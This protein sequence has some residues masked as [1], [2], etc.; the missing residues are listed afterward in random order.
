[1]Y[2]MADDRCAAQFPEAKN[3]GG[4]WIGHME[5]R[6]KKGGIF[7][8]SGDGREEIEGVGRAVEVVFVKEGLEAALNK[9]FRMRPHA[10]SSPSS[11]LP[12][13]F[14]KAVA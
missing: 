4:S 2:F 7:V 8:E 3:Y 9:S 12:W 1:M 10:V 11:T 13:P 5:I 14:A 6:F